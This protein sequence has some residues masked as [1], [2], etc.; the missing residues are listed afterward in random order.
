MNYAA[1]EPCQKRIVRHPVSRKNPRGEAT[2]D[3]GQEPTAKL[4]GE[5]EVKR[6]WS[7]GIS[8]TLLDR[9]RE[10]RVYVARGQN[11]FEASSGTYRYE[12]MHRVKKK[13]RRQPKWIRLLIGKKS[14]KRTE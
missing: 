2:A 9:S 7:A 1:G 3:A 8:K 12:P 13:L 14:Y 10:R 6:H 5:R 11:E 4:A